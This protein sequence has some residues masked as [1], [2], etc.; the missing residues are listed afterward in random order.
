MT[1]F[2]DTLA[3]LGTDVDQLKRDVAALG[4]RLRA[5]EN[6]VHRMPKISGDAMM[7]FRGAYLGK[8]SLIRANA[9][10]P[11]GGR[12]TDIDNRPIPSDKLLPDPQPIYALHPSLPPPP[13]PL[14][15]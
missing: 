14:S 12:A 11:A 7:G 13:P 5:L 10:G 8:G 3:A 6:E 9:A 1:E 2:Q 15:P 4:D